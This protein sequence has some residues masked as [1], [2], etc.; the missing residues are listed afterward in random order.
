MQAAVVHHRVER[1]EK[2]AEG[3]DNSGGREEQC[4]PLLTPSRFPPS[5]RSLVAEAYR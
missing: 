5:A 3:S 4:D 2:S 1:G